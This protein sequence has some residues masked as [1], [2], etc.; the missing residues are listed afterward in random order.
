M[1]FEALLADAG[2]LIA[3][4]MVSGLILKADLWAVKA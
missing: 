4:G 3:D 2:F 1:T